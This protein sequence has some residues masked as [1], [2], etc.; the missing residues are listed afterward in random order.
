LASPLQRWHGSRGAVIMPATVNPSRLA[1][2]SDDRTVSETR[3]ARPLHKWDIF[4]LIALL[5]WAFLVTVSVGDKSYDDAFITFRYAKNVASGEGFVYNPGERFLGTTKP[6]FTMALS[7]FGL[8]FPGAAIPQVGHWLC[9]VALFFCGLFVYLLGRDDDIPFAGFV[10]ASYA[11]THPLVL[12]IWGGEALLFLAL[13]LA[14]F[15]FFFRKQM[16]LCGI[17]LGLATLTRGEGVLAVLVLCGHSLLVNKRFPWRT[18]LAWAAIVVPWLVFSVFYFG[19]PLPGTLPAKMAQMASGYFAPSL[20]TSLRWLLAY[21]VPNASLPLSSSQTNLVVFLFAACGGL[22]LM[23]HP[24]FRWWGI[25]VWLGMYAAGYSLLWVPFYHWYAAPLVLGVA[26]AAGLGA[27]LVLDAIAKSSRTL[28]NGTAMIA[29][30]FLVATLALP[31]VR[32]I[33]V[34]GDYYQRPISLVQRLYTNAGLW[35]RENTPPTATV[36]YFEI[37][38]VGYYSQRTLVDAVGL[39]NPSVSERVAAGNFKWAYLRY[40]P[41]YLIVNPVRWYDR[42]GNI[43]EDNWFDDAYREVAAIEEPGYFDA[44]L[45]IYEKVNDAAIPR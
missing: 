10:A 6:L 36:G 35:L 44:P 8:M 28:G 20:S 5:G 31:V 27:Q 34:L 7:L 22:Y 9:G 45:T 1:P 11:V 40:R 18:A 25:V 33:V 24:R 29:R 26:M 12:S 17:A 14:G 32:A 23:L 21:A 41:D 37:G 15:V 2:R 30:V 43:R 16:T 42:I 3:V 39:V 38:F 13:V 4:F 19:S